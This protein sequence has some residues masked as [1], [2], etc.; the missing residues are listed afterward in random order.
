MHPSVDGRLPSDADLGGA[1]AIRPMRCFAEENE[2]GSEN[3]RGSSR[4]HPDKRD[5]TE[6]QIVVRSGHI[7]TK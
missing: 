3:V 5:G 1:G 2:K 6:G 7:S 4:V